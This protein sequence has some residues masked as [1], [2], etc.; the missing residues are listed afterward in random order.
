MNAIVQ[1]HHYDRDLESAIV[2]HILARPAA[3]SEV[4]E[5]CTV[6]DFTSETMARI[7]ETANAIRE[8]GFTPSPV[9]IKPR[10]SG[11]I[12][13]RV[14]A[15]TGYQLLDFMVALSR[16]ATPLQKV[17][18]LSR[19]L[20]EMSRRRR[21]DAELEAARE[22]L[23]TYDRPI[24]EAVSGALEVIGEATEYAAR[25][26]GHIGLAEAGMNMLKRL[27]DHAQGKPI[28]A[29]LT[30]LARLDKATGGFQAAIW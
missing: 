15:E 6:E 5:H 18:E 7:V 2:A 12:A 30:K 10:L 13:K 29:A 3:I 28:P 25:S 14:E 8:E 11:D 21:L 4:L 26:K 24:M 16:S 23:K 27:E 20:A 1:I 19:Q 17:A 22:R 9:T